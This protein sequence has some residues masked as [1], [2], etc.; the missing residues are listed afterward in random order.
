MKSTLA[1]CS[2]L[3]F[4]IA[5]VSC[6]KEEEAPVAETTASQQT[7]A[8]P[9]VT[10]AIRTE[11]YAQSAPQA[12]VPSQNM[13]QVVTPAPSA[14]VATKAGM[15]PSH[16]QAGHRCDIPVG[17]PLNSPVAKPAK[18]VANSGQPAFTQTTT[19]APT[20]TTPTPGTPA[21]LKADTPVVTAP[22]MNPPHGQEGHRC[23]IAVGQPLPPK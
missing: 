22:G 5:F 21:L 17:A 7:L 16:G 23:D 6:K 14:P 12:P 13:Q 1:F 3:A 9:A 11:N 18:P 8:F 15:N 10:P 4:S 19:T 2:L 20:P